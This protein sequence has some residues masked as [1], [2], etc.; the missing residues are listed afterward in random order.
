MFDELALS[1][2]FSLG[3]I[4]TLKKI[5][6]QKRGGLSPCCVIR[7]RKKEAKKKNNHSGEHRLS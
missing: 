7:G 5:N 4:L 2:D 1:K 3:T 6:H